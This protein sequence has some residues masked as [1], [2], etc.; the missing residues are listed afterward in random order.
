MDGKTDGNLSIF[1]IIGGLELQAAYDY[2]CEWDAL[3]D[4]L[5]CFYPLRPGE[6]KRILDKAAYDAIEKG[7]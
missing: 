6:I 2:Y 3:I 7:R 1:K 4:R 5:A